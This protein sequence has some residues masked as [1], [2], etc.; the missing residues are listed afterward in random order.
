MS[1]ILVEN[2]L[3]AFDERVNASVSTELS[4]ETYD[5]LVI[6]YFDEL[7]STNR[8]LMER[9]RNSASP[10]DFR[11]CVANFQTAGVGRQGRKWQSIGQSVTFSIQMPLDLSMD[12]LGGL[13]LAL[14][15]A[16]IDCLQ[17]LTR[18]RLLLKWPND[19]LAGNRK[20]SGIL[21]ESPGNFNGKQVLII[22]IGINYAGM[23]ELTPVVDRPV[24]TLEQLVLE[25][26]SNT[27]VLCDDENDSRAAN[28]PELPPRD[29]LIG[30]LLADVSQTV[31]KFQHAGW[32]AFAQRF[33]VLDALNGHEVS[34][35]QAT[36]RAV[37]IARGVSDDGNL[38]VE[39]AGSVR[40]FAAGDV[41]L[42]HC[43][44]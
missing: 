23:Q 38:L 33:A 31:R 8:Y 36:K 43:S 22:G 6:D 10:E 39:I 19:V 40:S 16:V 24:I 12:Q 28:A 15:T 11:A 5:N 20:L 2:I 4:A 25:K 17:T 21:I 9:Y 42:S 1:P 32:Q 14:G 35:S 29:R 41:S 13:S 30:Y 18:E 3:S 37:G 44:D 7:P 27:T 26:D 34:V